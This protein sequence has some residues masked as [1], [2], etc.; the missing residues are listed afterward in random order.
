M[1]IELVL[2]LRLHICLTTQT[3]SHIALIIYGLL[4]LQFMP[5]LPLIYLLLYLI[6]PLCHDL[7]T[8]LYIV[9]CM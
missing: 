5:L 4:Y 3:F 8:K 1:F 7:V 2:Y 9:K 6:V